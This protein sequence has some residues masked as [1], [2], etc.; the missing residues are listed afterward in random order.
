MSERGA[1]RL[2]ERRGVGSEIGVAASAHGRNPA[3]KRS[4][5]TPRW[6][7]PKT[8]TAGSEPAKPHPAS[9]AGPDRERGGS[10]S[11]G[12]SGSVTCTAIPFQA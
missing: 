8:T 9:C 6:R 10:E 1:R 11:G 4:K 5:P 12:W 2:P 3:A 7:C